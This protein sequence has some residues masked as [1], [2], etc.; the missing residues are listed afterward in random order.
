MGKIVN[1]A[2]RNSQKTAETIL[3]RRNK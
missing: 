2:R 3:K 1:K